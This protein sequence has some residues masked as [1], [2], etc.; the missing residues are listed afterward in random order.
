MRRALRYVGTTSMGGV[1]H[2]CLCSQQLV[3]SV[4][5]ELW[6]TS[7]PTGASQQ[8][9]LERRVLQMSAVVSPPH[10]SLGV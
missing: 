7:P 3:S 1:A 5:R 4:F 6:F 9:A 8:E 2:H 10:L